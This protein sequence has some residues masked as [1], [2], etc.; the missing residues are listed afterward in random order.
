[1]FYSRE[2]FNSILIG[3]IMKISQNSWEGLIKNKNKFSWIVSTILDVFV[4]VYTEAMIFSR[5]LRDNNESTKASLDIDIELLQEDD[6]SYFSRTDLGKANVFHMLH[7]ADLCFVARHKGKPIHHTCVALK[8][9]FHPRIPEK[10]RVNRNEAYIYGVCTRKPYGGY[11]VTPTVFEYIHQ[12]LRNHNIQR[13]FSH[14]WEGNLYSQKAFLKAGYAPYGK[15]L[16]V[17]FGGRHFWVV[18]GNRPYFSERCI[19]WL[20][21]FRLY[22]ATLPELRRIDHE[23]NPFIQKWQR[24]DYRVALFGTGGHSHMLLNAVSF[25]FGL[26]RFVVDNNPTKEGKEFEPLRLTIQSPKV[27][28]ELKFDVVIV[29]S[30]AYQEEMINQLIQE[31]C[32]RSQVIRL[33]PHVAYVE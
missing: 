30:R 7:D 10:I 22:R 20:P 16:L 3:D 33:Y 14:A 27:L 21:S 5:D 2:E 11:G 29:S 31:L 23:I 28:Q 6:I 25:P 24:L 17:H 8:P 15:L 1:M 26:I 4:K 9:F 19:L 13:V 32:T 18:K 12:S